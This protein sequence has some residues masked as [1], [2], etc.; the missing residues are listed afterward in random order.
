MEC[1]PFKDGNKKRNCTIRP[2]Y[3]VDYADTRHISRLS[4]FGSKTFSAFSDVWGAVKSKS[5]VFLKHATRSLLSF[6]ALFLSCLDPV[7][8]LFLCRPRSDLSS[9]SLSPQIWTQRGMTRSV[10]SPYSIGFV[11]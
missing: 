2:K 6:S 9:L 3:P 10:R 8:A 11:C 4:L 1:T 5:T 7:S